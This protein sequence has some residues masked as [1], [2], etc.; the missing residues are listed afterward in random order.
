MK[1]MIRTHRLL[2]TAAS[3]FIVL[4]LALVASTPASAQT[5]PPIPAGHIRIHYH[6]PDGNYSGWTVYAFYD[7]TENTGNYGGGPVQVTG[8][9]SY[10]AYFDVGVIANAQ[11][12]GLIIHNISSG[13]KKI[14]GPTE[15]VDPATEGQRVL[16]LHG[17]GP[18]YK[19]MPN[20]SESKCVAARLRMCHLLLQAQTATTTTGPS[21]HST[22]R[23]ST[24][25]TTTMD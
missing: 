13:D 15:F 14:L 21:T 22:I 20:I 18:P 16:G 11:N 3:P 9:D 4:L 10:G 8:T 5:D 6:R 7:T 12:V 17:H 1:F 2:C 24:P 19:S 25:A 23:L